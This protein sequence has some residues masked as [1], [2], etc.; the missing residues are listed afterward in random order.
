MH[1][2]LSVHARASPKLAS[3][4]HVAVDNVTLTQPPALRYIGSMLDRL[5]VAFMRLSAHYV[6]RIMK[7]VVGNYGSSDCNV[8]AWSIF[9]GASLAGR[10]T[11]CL[12]YRNDCKIKLVRVLRASPEPSFFART[13]IASRAAWKRYYVCLDRMPK[14]E[15]I[16]V[17]CALM[18]K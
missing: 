15:G 18:R 7:Y 13:L 17:T 14:A 8:T 9:L 1:S 4:A 6:S 3:D 2:A 11:G 12:A 10:A 5:A 16:H